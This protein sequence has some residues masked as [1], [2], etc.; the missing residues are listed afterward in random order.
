MARTSGGRY[1]PFN[2][3]VGV[4]FAAAIAGGMGLSQTFLTVFGIV[5]VPIA[6]EFGW[7][8]SMV[9]GV[10]SLAVIKSLTLTLV[11]GTLVDWFGPRR[12]LTT[13]LLL[14]GCGLLL[15]AFVPMNIA[16]FYAAFGL[17]CALGAPMAGPTI[18]KALAGWFDTNRG[19]AIG[20][21][22]GLGTGIGS[23]VFPVLA[24]ALLPVV[25]W[26]GVIVAVAA[27]VL[28]FAF[29][30]VRALFRDPPIAGD[31]GNAPAAAAGMSLKAAIRTPVFWSLMGSVGICAGCMTGMFTQM[32]PIV[33][34][35]GFSLEEGVATVSLFALVCAGSQWLI[36]SLIDRFSRPQVMIPFY[37]MGIAGLWLVMHAGSTE[38][39]L[40]AG[41]LMGLCLGAEYSSL[42][43]L[44]SRY[45]GL[46]HFGKI[47]A[48]AYGLIAVIAGLVPLAMNA[49]FDAFGSYFL[50]IEAMQAV[51]LAATLLILPLP[52]RLSERSIGAL[53]ERLVFGRSTAKR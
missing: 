1:L 31:D 16:L 32:V 30:I 27:V 12:V 15:F 23:A 5:M 50:A 38:V 2:P 6:E 28:L 25:G 53:G 45:F 3:R 18:A 47:S 24:G 39:L 20:L 33:R 51:M 48:L 46:A 29:P 41:V 37:L 4:A 44:L 49:G 22:A 36:G 21:S 13:A 10:M 14:Y 26:R 17:C 19:A 52:S 43:V 11:V 8:R 7:S 35:S 34:D 9:A 40:A 42:P